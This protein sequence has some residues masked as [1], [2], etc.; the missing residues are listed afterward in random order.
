MGGEA[1][2]KGDKRVTDTGQKA[3]KL[4]NRL[5][6]RVLKTNKTFWLQLNQVVFYSCF[7]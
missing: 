1:I 6:I 5:S 4:K 2:K 7:Y 3:D